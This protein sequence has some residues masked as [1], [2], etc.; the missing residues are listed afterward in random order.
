[1]EDRLGLNIFVKFLALKTISLWTFI[2]LEVYFLPMRPGL[3]LICFVYCQTQSGLIQLSNSM[4]NTL[5]NIV[6][7]EIEKEQE[8]KWKNIELFFLY[9]Y[10]MSFCTNMTT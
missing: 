6:Y 1:M 3:E 10:F 9:L 4:I 2:C 8:S 5:G 7:E